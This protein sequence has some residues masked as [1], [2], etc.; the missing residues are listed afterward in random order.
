MH[1]RL[2]IA[3]SGAI[4]CGLAATAARHA[5]DVL[6]WARSD[7]SADRARGTVEKVCGRLSGEVQA[8]HVRVVTDIEELASCTY[9]VEAIAEIHDAKAELISELDSHVSHD[10]ILASTTSSLSVTELAQ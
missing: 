2:G 9:V 4:A 6:L 7:E 10:A 3:G 1:E 5:E 8:K